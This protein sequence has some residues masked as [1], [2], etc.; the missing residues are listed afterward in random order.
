[1]RR[2]G[3]CAMTYGMRCAL[4]L[5]PLLVGCIDTDPAVFVEASVATPSLAV[6]TSAL[7]TGLEGTVDVSLHLGSRASGPSTTTLPAAS[8][9]DE[10]GAT[11]LAPT[12]GFT[13]SPS[14]PVTVP[15][16]DTVIVTLSFAA[17]DNL[18]PAE[19]ASA[20]CAEKPRIRLLV[21]DSLRGVPA[22]I[23]SPPFTPSGCN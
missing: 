8:L 15:V 11:T 1:M 4:G 21:D 5:V 17:K 10:A 6:Q 2:A 19:R 9:V 3:S 12:L 20:I 22:T 7:A 13:A 23:D 16:D 14:V 18:L